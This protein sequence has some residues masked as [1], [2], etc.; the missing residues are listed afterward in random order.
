MDS[1]CEENV[2]TL[3]KDYK[4]KLNELEV[5]QKTSIQ[6]MWLNELDILEQELLKQ[7]KK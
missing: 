1:V 4:D 3:Q 6:Q 7:S 2:Q 5:I